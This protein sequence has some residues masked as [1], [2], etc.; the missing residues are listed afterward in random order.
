M[1]ERQYKKKPKIY[2]KK[3]KSLPIYAKRG[4]PRGD[5]RYRN[6]VGQKATELRKA[7]LKIVCKHN[8]I[9]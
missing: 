1:P 9:T 3:Y 8:Y 7:E 6:R 4:K 2:L 5:W